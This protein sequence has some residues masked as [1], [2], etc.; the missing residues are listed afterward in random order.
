M[1]PFPPQAVPQKKWE[2]D[3]SVAYGATSH[4]FD[5]L[6]VAYGATSHHFDALSVAYGATSPKGRGL[7]EYFA[8]SP[9]GRA[10]R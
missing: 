8:G 10:P 4:H 5:A 6:S 1:E 7:R 9:L 3:L 2:T